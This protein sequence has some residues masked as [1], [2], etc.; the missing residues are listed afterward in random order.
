MVAGV[1]VPDVAVPVATYGKAIRKQG[2]GE[3]D[4]CHENGSAIAFAQ[5]KTERLAHGDSRLSIAE[6]Y[7]GGQ[8]E[9]AKKYAAAVD[10]LVSERYLL[11]MDAAKLKT[12][13]SLPRASN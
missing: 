10:K 6:R 5:T 8:A 9:Y 3:G 12:A 1:I 13:A 4:L 7:P 2:F 11:P